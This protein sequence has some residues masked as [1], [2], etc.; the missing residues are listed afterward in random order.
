MH[1]KCY[2]ERIK[3]AGDAITGEQHFGFEKR[4]V[5]VVLRII[6][7]RTYACVYAYVSVCV[8]IRGKER[9]RGTMGE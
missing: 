1:A 5:R 2:T 4:N 3:K 9:M 7:V 8:C 6:Y